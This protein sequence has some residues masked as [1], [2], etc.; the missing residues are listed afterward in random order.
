MS[1]IPGNHDVYTRGSERAQRFSQYFAPYLH[2]RPARV[3]GATTRRARSRS[4]ASAA[5]SPSS[6]SP[7]PSRAC[8]SFASGRAGERQLRALSDVL[9]RPEVQSRTPVILVHHPLVNPPGFVIAA[10]HGLVEGRGIRRLLG[11]SLDRGLVLH[12]HTHERTHRELKGPGGETIHHIGATSASLVHS[13]ERR[14]AGYNVYEFA[15]D[16]AFVGATARVWDQASA[17]FV[18]GGTIAA[19]RPRRVAMSGPLARE[20]LPNAPCC[21]MVLHA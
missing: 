20:R 17:S 7:R 14:M 11:S 5:R 18:D 21:A 1:V 12:G 9:D 15:D 4:F 13:A 16:G 8:R 19:R 3:G 2:V 6:G 10:T